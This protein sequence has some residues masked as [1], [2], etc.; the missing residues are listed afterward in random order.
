LIHIFKTQF[1]NLPR[2]TS[3][4]FHSTLIIRDVPSSYTFY[5]NCILQF[6]SNINT[7]DYIVFMILYLYVM[8][9]KIIYV[10]PKRSV[11]ELLSWG[12]IRSCNSSLPGNH[13]RHNSELFRSERKK[14]VS[15]SLTT[16]CSFQ[17]LVYIKQ[18]YFWT[19]SV[20]VSWTLSFSTCT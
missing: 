3:T 6:V 7:R 4:G 12:S 18:F 14:I 17:T 11:I 16:Q 1:I 13:S 8:F 9:K 15:P 20:W 5:V 19:F 10:A 2:H